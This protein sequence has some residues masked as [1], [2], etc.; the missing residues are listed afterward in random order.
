VARRRVWWNGVDDARITKFGRC[1]VMLV[2]NW[3]REFG[4]LVRNVEVR[5]LS[6]VSRA[7]ACYPALQLDQDECMLPILARMTRRIALS[8]PTRLK[9]GISTQVSSRPS[10]YKHISGNSSDY[11]SHTKP[12]HQ[13]PTTQPPKTPHTKIPI[14]ARGLAAPSKRDTQHR[15]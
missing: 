5:L 11:P 9:K 7:R 2:S 4:G 13:A 14:K 12:Q 15:T 10:A 1:L 3:S 6:F 8:K